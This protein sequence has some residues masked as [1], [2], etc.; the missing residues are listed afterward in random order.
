MCATDGNV[1]S[2][3]AAKEIFFKK[4]IHFSLQTWSFSQPKHVHSRNQKIN[5][6]S[7]NCIFQS[8][9]FAADAIASVNTRTFALGFSRI[10]YQS[11]LKKFETNI[12][13]VFT[14]TSCS[15]PLI[16]LFSL[17]SI[18]TAHTWFQ[19]SVQS[20]HAY[21]GW[22]IV[23][24]NRTSTTSKQWDQRQPRVTCSKVA[25]GHC[26]SVMLKYWNCVPWKESQMMKGYS[27]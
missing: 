2:Q 1:Q 23:S 7:C 14:L 16:L 15:Q 24:T 18:H 13:S 26:K 11:F 22:F 3:N 12:D 6:N 20:L 19:E 25:R 17:R 8:W 27:Q 21:R 5:W 9:L 4:I 10:V